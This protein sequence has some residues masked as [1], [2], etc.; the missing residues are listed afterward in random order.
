MKHFRT[1]LINRLAE[2]NYNVRKYYNEL[3]HSTNG[4]MWE[5]NIR[6]LFE[7]ID[8]RNFLDVEWKNLYKKIKTNT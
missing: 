2:Y 3:C 1:N 6:Q 4:V 7:E 8:G 5:Q